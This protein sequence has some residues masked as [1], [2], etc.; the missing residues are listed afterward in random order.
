MN[1]ANQVASVTFCNVRSY[2]NRESITNRLV[3]FIGTV[4]LCFK[5]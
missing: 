1:Q 4:Y 3:Q 5:I 2:I